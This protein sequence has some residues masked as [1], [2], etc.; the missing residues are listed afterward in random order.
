MY[1]Y[2]KSIGFSSGRKDLHQHEARVGARFD[3]TNAIQS[4]FL[5]VLGLKRLKGAQLKPQ[6]L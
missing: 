6:Q 5:P 4:F 3:D 1:P 2:Q